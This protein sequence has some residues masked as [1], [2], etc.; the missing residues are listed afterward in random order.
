MSWLVNLG[1]VMIHPRQTMRRIL[2][3]PR[4][5]MVIPLLILAI[6][7]SYAADFNREEYRRVVAMADPKVIIMAAAG[8][9]VIVPALLIGVIYLFAWLA[10]VVGRMLQG[11]GDARGMRSA[12]AWGSAPV[13]WALLYRVPAAIWAA[14]AQ[15]DFRVE[16][17]QLSLEGLKGGC[18]A[19]AVFLLLELI[20]LAWSIVAMSSTVGEAH[21]FSTARGFVTLAICWIAPVVIAVAAALSF[22]F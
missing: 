5:R 2:D 20:T 18:V 19:T 10:G 7:S 16:D 9:L 4:D 13:I 11:T 22:A 17:F 12:L 14:R 8:L 6:L 21:R 3:A 1:A 15:P